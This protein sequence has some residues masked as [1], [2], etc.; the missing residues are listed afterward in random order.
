M[1]DA[2]PHKLATGLS[3]REALALA[4]TAPVAVSAVAQSPAA[5]SSGM[6]VRM[7]EPQNLEADFSKVNT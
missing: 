2:R 7:N 3:R 4:V 1:T 6:T 5:P